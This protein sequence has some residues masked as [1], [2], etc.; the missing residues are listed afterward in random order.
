MHSSHKT[1]VEVV[2]DDLYMPI[3]VRVGVDRA[4]VG[5]SLRQLGVVANILGDPNARTR[6][7]CRRA[8]ASGAGSPGD[9]EPRI[10][11]A[12]PSTGGVRR[13]SCLPAQPGLRFDS[14]ARAS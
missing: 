11:S 4:R 12:N 9:V 1:H 7:L 10:A 6:R 2:L 13:T 5:K 3:A 14:D 8:D